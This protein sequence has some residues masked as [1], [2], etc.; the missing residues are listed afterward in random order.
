LFGFLANRG[1][2]ARFRKKG[3]A[4]SPERA[5]MWLN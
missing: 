4:E 3:M 5:E 2:N 1:G